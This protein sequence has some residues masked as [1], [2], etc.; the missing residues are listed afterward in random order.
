[1]TLGGGEIGVQRQGPV[2]TRQ[3]EDARTRPDGQMISNCR[4]SGR[5]V[6]LA[7]C[8][9]HGAPADPLD[10]NGQVRSGAG[11]GRASRTRL[12]GVSAAR[13]NREKPASW[14]TSPSRVSPACAP[15]ASPTS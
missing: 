5:E 7:R 8:L 15:S 11:Q 4:R 3:L 14:T 10:G 13:R 6:D 2:A 1:V 9:D 12:N